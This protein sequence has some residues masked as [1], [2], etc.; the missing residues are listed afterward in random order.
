MFLN[1]S[2]LL[3]ELNLW[4]GSTIYFQWLFL[5]SLSGL[6]TAFRVSETLSNDSLFL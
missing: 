2:A 1:D 5:D 6:S 4:K 3:L